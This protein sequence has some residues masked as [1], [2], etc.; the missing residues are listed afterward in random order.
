MSTPARTKW[1]RRERK[2]LVDSE[3]VKH[4]LDT[5]E[6]PSGKFIDFHAIEFPM[7]VVGIVPVGEDGRILLT[8]Q[9]RYMADAHGWEI[10]A[11]NIPAGESRE[12]GARRELLEETGYSARELKAL[13]SFYPQIGRSNHYFHLYSAHGLTRLTTEFDRDEVSEL[14]WFAVPEILTMIRRNEL[15]DGFTA[16][17]LLVYNLHHPSPSHA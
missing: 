12:E 8:Y 14:G 7:E 11:G 5:L 17:A 13:Y 3:W 10:P 9:Y 2:T 6:L 4:H 16:L 1:L 15:R